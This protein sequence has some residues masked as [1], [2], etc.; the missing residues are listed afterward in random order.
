MPEKEEELN[1]PQ[2]TAQETAAPQ[3]AA[4]PQGTSAPAPDSGSR[5]SLI[6]R[7]KERNYMVDEE[8][9]EALINAVLGYM[10]E[11]KGRIDK[12]EESAKRLMDT[13]DKDAIAGDL[14]VAMA[15][16]ENPVVYL[17]RRWGPDILEWIKTDEGI[18]SIQKA[19]DEFRAKQEQ[20]GKDDEEW[21]RNVSASIDRLNAF[22]Q[23]HGLDEERQTEVF[24]RLWELGQKFL[25][26]NYDDA[27]F[28]L[29]LKALGYD[30]DVAN[31][32]EEGEIEGR[33]TRI[34]EKLRR[35]E[36][37]RSMPTPMNGGGESPDET[38]EENITDDERLA[39]DPFGAMRYSNR[40]K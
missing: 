9:N 35:S 4:A 32:R 25:D 27:D 14:F 22:A 20:K 1:A 21:T 5:A 6:A 28:E 26:G 36:P 23:S 29:A 19:A 38:P 40:R 15:H 37:E 17:I 33:N 11:D 24:N 18:A 13:I 7:L 39:R 2:E 3:E 34:T 10:D 8:D 12:Y 31:A 30:E 16:D